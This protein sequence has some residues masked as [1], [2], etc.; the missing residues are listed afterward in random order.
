MKKQHFYIDGIPTI[1][2]GNPTEKIFILIHG[3]GSNKEEAELFANIVKTKGYGVI[4]FDMPE[5]G[6]RINEAKPLRPWNCIEEI[7]KVYRYAQSISPHIS[8]FATSLGAYMCLLTFPEIK[9][10]RALF[11]SP[12]LDLQRLI[13]NLMSAYD[14]T[15]T[16]IMEKREIATPAGITLYDDY[17]NYVM[18]HPIVKWE[19]PTEI[20]YGEYD[21]L[22]EYE[23][24]TGFAERYGC[25]LEVMENGEHWFHTEDQL[26]YFSDWV[27]KVITN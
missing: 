14:I 26:A 2:W 23:I 20:L 25:G 10:E 13:R 19:T 7:V 3:A 8:V 5:H 15:E 27:D 16:Q 18:A 21:N 9:L 22:T 1:Y 4:S 6:E 17:Y 11:L 12:I 24:V